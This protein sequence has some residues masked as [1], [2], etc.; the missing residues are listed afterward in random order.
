MKSDFSEITMCKES[1]IIPLLYFPHIIK[2][3][4]AAKPLTLSFTFR[5]LLATF[6]NSVDVLYA[7]FTY[8]NNTLLAYHDLAYLQYIC[9]VHFGFSHL[10]LVTLFARLTTHLLIFYLLTD[11]PARPAIQPTTSTCTVLLPTSALDQ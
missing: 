11:R 8:L 2:Y 10:C 3:V 7:S 9:V 1:Y 6:Q 5:H 4:S